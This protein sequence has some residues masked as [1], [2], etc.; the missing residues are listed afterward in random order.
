[1]SES[2]IS[3]NR[4]DWVPFYHDFAK[5][6]LPFR[7]NQATLIEYIK[8]AFGNAGIKVPTLDDNGTIDHMD[9]FTVMGLF[10]KSGMKDDKRLKI[11]KSLTL[12]FSVQASLPTRFDGIPVLYPLGA[13]FY[14]FAEKGNDSLFDLLWDLLETGLQYADNKDSSLLPKLKELITSA[15]RIKYNGNSKITMALY[16]ISPET[17]INLDSRN[18]WYIYKSGKVPEQMVS[19]LPKINGESLTGELYFEILEGVKV[20]L[21]DLGFKGFAELSYEAWRYSEEDNLREKLEKEKTKMKQVGNGLADSDV[22]TTH[23]W[24]YSPG[25]GAAQ[26]DEFYQAGI[27]AIDWDG[28][29]GDL[30]AYTSREEIRKKLQEH[31]GID[32]SYK[33]DSLALWQF[34]NEI[35]P[36]DIVYAKKGMH[37]I[38]GRGIVTTDYTFSNSD[39][40]YNNVRGINWTNNGE[41]AYPGQAAMKVLTDITQYTDIIASLESLFKEEA[42]ETSEPDIEDEPVQEYPPYTKEQFLNEVY[43]DEED[44]NT[45]A[46]LLKKKKNI[47]L[48]GAPGVG[49]TY[50]A[51]RLA[52]ALMGE[53]N[54]DRVMMIQFHQ[55]Y[56]YEDFIEGF[57]PGSEGNQ[58]VIKKGSFY[59]FCRKA[60]D[61]LD[62]DYYFI[63]DEI[64]R[65]N[66]SR[67]FGEL[68]MLIEADKRGNAL[69]LLYSD[70]KFSVPGNIY[71]IGTMNTADRSLALLDYAL[72]RRFAFYSMKPGFETAGFRQY[73]EKLNNTKFNKLIA[74]I[75]NLNEAIAKD[76][77]LGEGFCIGHSYFCDLKEITDKALR[78]IVEYE[79][80]PLLREYW[81]D[82]KDK[83]E[84]AIAGLKDAIR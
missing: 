19:S 75:K 24:L 10:N 35:Q 13:T 41:W 43:M 84:D 1:M 5:A 38:I 29:A 12:F 14:P 42:S 39:T 65:G 63:I 18:E 62:N 82:E 15:I 25:V 55:G 48:Q 32:R 74:Q 83:A 77:S 33:N 47:I 40:N 2:S 37:K 26:W 44:L 4:F 71:I 16:W 20:L 72:R 80:T 8:T 56:S 78:D 22:R 66:M 34:A 36:G 21:P 73:K 79:I 30:T 53:K 81:Y 60:A 45:L 23:Y 9:P 11:I 52:Y 46:G 58:F 3:T 54:Q 28:P 27:M 67:I 50:T 69:Q 76:D 49:K 57:R 59:Q 17:F 61:D 68:F 64:N 51:K 7:N 70:E 31:Y 6:L